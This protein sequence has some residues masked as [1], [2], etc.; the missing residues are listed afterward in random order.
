MKQKGIIFV[1]VLAVFNLD[2]FGD[3]LHTVDRKVY[4]GKMVA[5]KFNTIYFNVYKFGKIQGTKR[6]P[7]YRVWKIEFNEPQKEGLESPFEVEQNYNRLRKGKRLKKVVLTGDQKWIDTGI[8]VRIGQEILFLASGSIQI[9]EKTMV[10]QSGEEYV[11]WNKNKPLP[12][13]PTGAVI[14]RVGKKGELF[15]IGNDKA[16]FQMAEKGRLFVGINDFDF[17]DNSGQFTVIIYH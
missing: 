7:L 5:F 15:Y 2:L 11:N 8:D 12:N 1:I 3:F 13:Q 17:S 10:Y 16:P 4:E 14:G 6:F 9:D